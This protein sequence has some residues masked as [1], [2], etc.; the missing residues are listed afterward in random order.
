MVRRCN[1]WPCRRQ[2]MLRNR[3]DAADEGSPRAGP[4]GVA[5][6]RATPNNGLVGQTQHTQSGTLLCVHEVAARQALQRSATVAPWNRPGCN[7]ANQQSKLARPGANYRHCPTE[8]IVR[9][10]P[11]PRR[12]PARANPNATPHVSTVTVLLHIGSQS[13]MGAPRPAGVLGACVGTQTWQY[14]RNGPPLREL[15]CC[16]KPTQVAGPRQPSATDA[17]AHNG[18]LPAKLTNNKNQACEQ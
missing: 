15:S 18:P 3:P 11:H 9:P 12:H 5:A 8:A 6:T 4:H 10:I 2:D 7:H 14:R 1:R 17:R 13:T 16:L